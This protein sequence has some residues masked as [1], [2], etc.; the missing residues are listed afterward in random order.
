MSI[1]AGMRGRWDWMLLVAMGGLLLI[2]TLGILSASL[3]QANYG[4]VLQRH[5]LALS[6]GVG[7][8]LLGV[9]VNYQVFQD[10]S[11]ALYGITLLLLVAVLFVGVKLRGQRAWFQLPFFNFQ[12]SEFARVCTVLVLA[13]FLDR[14]ADRIHHLKTFLQAGGLCA[15][16]LVLIL[17]EPDFSSCLVFFPM[18]LAMLFCAGANVAHILAMGLYGSLTLG[19]PLLWTLLSL[20]PQWVSS[21]PTAAFLL[22]LST[23]GKSLLL[24]AAGIFLVAFFLWKL[25]HWARAP[26]HWLIFATTAMVV[27]GGLGSAEAINHQIKGYQRKRFLAFLAPEI[28]PQGASYNVNQALVAIGSGGMGGKGI[29]SGT[30]SQLGFL[31]ERHTDF[32]FAVIGEEM[33]FWGASAVLLLY[34]MLIWRVVC[35]ARLSRD[36]YGFLVCAGLAAMYTAYLA[37][38]VGMCLGLFPVAGL[39][40]PLVSYGGSSLV[41]NL[42]TLGIVMNIYSHHYSFA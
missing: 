20:R 39:P 21:S 5:F 33:G 6:I 30:Q 15:L 31:P 11:K 26:V 35:A 4:Q 27:L 13:T 41:I 12:V 2:G 14:R 24:A 3:G 22:S 23:P 19:L 10:Q 28:D 38:N 29:F 1:K 40:L 34:L 36:R 8:F 25:T 16:V 32:I 37:I 7:L 18:S 9:S 17:K 42:W